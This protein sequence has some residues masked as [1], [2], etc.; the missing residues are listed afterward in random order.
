MICRRDP[1]GCGSY[2]NGDA[3]QDGG[4][5]FLIL[6]HSVAADDEH[7]AFVRPGCEMRV[8]HLGTRLLVK[9]GSGESTEQDV[10]DEVERQPE[11]D[12]C[13]PA[14]TQKKPALEDV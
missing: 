1:I 10:P 7:D 9:P 6:R 14:V 5:G 8:S 3:V 4:D 11:H 13:K 2:C 12:G